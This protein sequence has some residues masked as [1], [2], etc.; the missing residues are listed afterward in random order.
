MSEDSG[1]DVIVR[2]PAVEQF[3]GKKRSQIYDDVKN[4]LFPAPIRL[5]ASENGQAIGW[6]RRELLAWQRERI[7]ERDAMLATEPAAKA[8]PQ[9]KKKRARA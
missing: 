3:T 7:A 5:S 1:P 2:L 9:P 6:L 4:K 8:E